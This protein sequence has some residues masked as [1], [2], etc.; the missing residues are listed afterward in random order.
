MTG[1]AVYRRRRARAR[2]TT[3]RPVTPVTSRRLLA[4]TSDQ[5]GRLSANGSVEFGAGPTRSRPGSA[6]PSRLAQGH[7]GASLAGPTDPIRTRDMIRSGAIRV[8]ALP[9]LEQLQDS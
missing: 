1:C 9:E 2:G 7:V 6:V 3:C 4:E 5:V 8:G